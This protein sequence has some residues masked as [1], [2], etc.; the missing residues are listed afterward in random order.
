MQSSAG[1]GSWAAGPWSPGSPGTPGWCCTRDTRREVTSK[2]THTEGGRAGSSQPRPRPPGTRKPR[3]LRAGPEGAPPRA[4]AQPAPPAW[5]PPAPLTPGGPTPAGGQA[6]RASRAPPAR[7]QVGPRWAGWRG[8]QPQPSSLCQDPNLA[9]VAASCLR[10]DAREGQRPVGSRGAGG[11]LA[12][13]PRAH[14]QGAWQGPGGGRR[15]GPG[16]P[17][18]PGWPCAG[19]GLGRPS[20]PAQVSIF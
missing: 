4:S 14:P 11:N 5:P 17:H 16:Q 3:S 10:D 2:V 1:R 20:T 18:E 9:R 7:P 19:W 6:F 12:R 8:V 15:R 13:V